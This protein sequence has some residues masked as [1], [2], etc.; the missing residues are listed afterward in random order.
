MRCKTGQLRSLIK[1]N[2]QDQ[3]KS[4]PAPTFPLPKKVKQL[5]REY[6]DVEEVESLTNT[7]LIRLYV[8]IILSKQKVLDRWVRQDPALAQAQSTEELTQML[9]DRLS[10]ETRYH[11]CS[12]INQDTTFQ[13]NLELYWRDLLAG[14][15]ECLLSMSL[16]DAL[17]YMSDNY[18]FGPMVKMEET[19]DHIISYLLSSAGAVDFRPDEKLPEDDYAL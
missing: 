12:W 16:G 7:G 10:R 11:L 18:Y 3:V 6:F 17:D 13:E 9:T 4:V 5:V 1:E 15:Q 2:L 19:K 8:D 14:L